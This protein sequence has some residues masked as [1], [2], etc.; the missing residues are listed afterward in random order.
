MIR[1]LVVDDHELVR[2]GITRMLADNPDIEA[3]GQASSGEDA[4]EFV[5]KDRPDIVLMDIRMPGIGG[6]EATRRI[7]RIDDSIR[8][9]VV[10]ACADDPYPARVMQSGATAYITK[11]ADIQEMVRAI[12]KAH[13][14]Q[15]YISPEIA[16]KMALKTLGGDREEDGELSRFERLSERE[17]QIAMMVVDC[18]KVQDISDKLCLSPKTVNS[19]RYRIF[20][21]LEISSDVELALMAVRLGLLDADKV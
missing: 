10:T 16:Q 7:L 11:G 2:S 14:G 13:S 20:E 19:Y 6:L 8:V 17:M 12:R 5:R 4:I 21:K 1:V 18:Q 9:I 15:R 3:I